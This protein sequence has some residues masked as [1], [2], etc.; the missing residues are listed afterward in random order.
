MK[1]ITFESQVAKIEKFYNGFTASHLIHIGD[2]LGL[3]E[4]LNSNKNGLTT[5]ELASELG[6]HEPYLKIWCHLLNL[7]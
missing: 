7:K 1:E 4:V 2:K 6:L 5:S 3:F